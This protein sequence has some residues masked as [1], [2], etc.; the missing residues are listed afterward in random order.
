MYT[1][2][3]GLINRECT[4]DHYI[5]NIPINS[6]VVVSVCIS[7][8]HFRDE[9]YQDP[10]VFNPYR[11]DNLDEKKARFIPFIPFSLGSRVC[12]GQ[13]LAMIEMKIAIVNF[14]RRYKE[15]ILEKPEYVFSLKTVYSPQRM[16]T[17][18]IK[19]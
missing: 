11:W 19:A 7:G 16:K 10:E 2:V 13:H 9:F 3:P 4:K 8:Y 17:T 5:G 18:L 1:P 6:G 14:L 15:I 12:I